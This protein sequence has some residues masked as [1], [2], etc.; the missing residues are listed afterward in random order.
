MIRQIPYM[1]EY[2]SKYMTLN[3]GDMIL[4]G[5]PAGVGS[6]KPGNLL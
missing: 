5:T 3:E 6:V 1:L 4:T 2:V